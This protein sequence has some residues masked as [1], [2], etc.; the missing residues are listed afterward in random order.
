MNRLLKRGRRRLAVAGAAMLMAA[1]M[2]A[3]PAP[4][5]YA[6]P[7]NEDC[8]TQAWHTQEAGNYITAHR[9]RVCQ[10]R[11]FEIALSV[12]IERFQVDGVYETV[13]TGRGS[14][15]YYCA[16][17]AFNRYRTTG[18]RDFDILCG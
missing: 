1:G 9:W 17:S 11:T 8:W 16:G 4:P 14:V 3:A 15:T 13:A 5:A 6:E 18:T 2:V 7:P 12:S 10:N